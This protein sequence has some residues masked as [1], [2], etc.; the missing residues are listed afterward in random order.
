MAYWSNLFTRVADRLG[1]LRTAAHSAHELPGV[2]RSVTAVRADAND[3]A[4]TLPSDI[5]EAQLLAGVLQRY[6][7]AFD[8]HA[9]PANDLIDDIETA[10]AKWSR[11][12][13]AADHAG[14]A[15]M[16]AAYGDDQAEIDDSNDAVSEAI[17]ER[18]AAKDA[19]DELWA[20]YERCY[21]DWDAAYAVALSELAGASGAALTNEARDFLDALLAATSPEE[22]ARL[23]LEN[24]ELQ[25]EL[26][27]SHPAIIG[28]L[29]GI[30]W[31]V[32]AAVNAARLDE[33]L[34]TEPEGP[35]RDDLLAIRTALKRGG[36]PAPNLITFDPDGSEQVTAA[37][38]YGDLSTASEIN[39][40]IPGMNGNVHDLQAWG[41]SA[42]ALNSSVGPGSATVVW[43]GYDT[44]GF[45]EEPAMDRAQ[46]GAASLRSYLLA[47]RALS[48]TADVNVIAHS[49]GSTTAALAIGSQPDGLGV[50]SFV[51]VGS[52]GFPNDPIVV[53]NLTNGK[54]P[55]IYA[56]ISEDDAVA[57]VG[58]G[59][60]PEH[61]VSP[62]RLPGT[63][64]FD[65]DGGVSASGESLPAATGHDALGPGAYLEQGSESFYNVSEIIQTAQ[66]GTERG[67]EG[68]T[69]GFWDANNWWIS[70]EYAL[71]D[72]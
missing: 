6:A 53:E 21:G 5:A 8:L 13:L 63:T 22:V 34:E 20:E 64:V 3:L 28:N 10:H 43:F 29:D 59:T 52:A 24:P 31:D 57:R 7:D 23:W 67:G 40:L 11:L 25:Q 68:S 1:D 35:H 44:P 58:R 15:A 51:A 47:V 14:R 39:T 2:G 26:A 4:A 71:I 36:V 19:L 69:Q 62:E 49:Y 41:E 42:K 72:F 61:P 9:K 65:S 33:L 37:I 27:G 66:P 17:G 38:A 70:D 50:T 16:A 60:A 32:R 48:P 55:Q 12:D 45:F 56:T 18:E 54:P 30:P 46:D